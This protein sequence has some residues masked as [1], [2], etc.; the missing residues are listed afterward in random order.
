MPQATDVYAQDFPIGNAAP[1][2][3][4]AGHGAVSPQLPWS[5]RTADATYVGQ[6]GL[7]EKPAPHPEPSANAL[8][9][10][11]L[12]HLRTVVLPRVQ[13]LEHWEG[14]VE[15][16]GDGVVY[17]RLRSLRHTDRVEQGAEV[18][19]DAFHP[20]ERRLVEPGTVFSWT[21]GY[22]TD[23]GTRAGFSEVKVRRLPAWSKR[24]VA[25]IAESARRWDELFDE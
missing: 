25:R 15:S 13:L 6:G 21:V 3:T 2:A 8:A 7:P 10:T 19:I 20:S 18:E 17:A 14:V 12:P 23:H 16:I 24:D 11:R 4:D 22:R 5:M 9:P 1:G